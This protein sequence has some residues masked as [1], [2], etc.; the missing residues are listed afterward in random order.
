MSFFVP[1]LNFNAQKY[2]RSCAAMPT[3]FGDPYRIH[4]VV[5]ILIIPE[6]N[7][8]QAV[9]MPEYLRQILTAPKLHLCRVFFFYSGKLLVLGRCLRSWFDYSFNI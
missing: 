7:C 5:H 9:A 6:I 4:V 2:H 8:L 1:A 3:A